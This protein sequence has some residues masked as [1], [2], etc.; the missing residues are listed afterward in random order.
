M[1]R[2]ALFAHYDSE[3]TVKPYVFAFLEQLRAFGCDVVFVSNSPLSA[4]ERERLRTY[5]SKIFEREN[6]GFDF[7]M[8]QYAL[9]QVSLAG[10]DELILTNSSVVGPVLSLQA[11]FQQMETRSCDFWGM[12]D[13]HE[14]GWHLQSYFLVFRERVLQSQAFSR[15]WHSVLPYRDKLQVI[16][17]Y[18]LGLTR[19]LT[20]QGFQA[21][22]LVPIASWASPGL[23]K[24]MRR[25]RRWN[26]TLFFPMQL[27]ERGMPFV[28]VG[29]LRDNVGRVALAPLLKFIENAGFPL[30]LLPGP[31]ARGSRFWKL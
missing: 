28:K 26:A 5:A 15:F 19:Y 24:R 9:E 16:R 7:C 14:L 3:A 4:A 18:E 12:T 20:E 30:D 29:L 17:S 22:A 6:E 1:Y 10:V 13:S 2:L 27:L 31:L 8:W 25:T 21:E 11:A 23:Q